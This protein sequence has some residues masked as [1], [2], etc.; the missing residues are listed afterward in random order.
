[1]IVKCTKVQIWGT[2]PCTKYCGV[3]DCYQYRLT[4]HNIN[5]IYHDREVLQSARMEQKSR[6][7]T[8][9]LKVYS[10]CGVTDKSDVYHPQH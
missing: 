2:K 8:Y 7:A 5:H 10:N 6:A 3:S 1:M 9:C 4:I